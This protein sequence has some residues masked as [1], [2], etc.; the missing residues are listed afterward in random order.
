MS[1]WSRGAKAKLRGL[2]Q[3]RTSTFAL[4]SAP[5]GALGCGR[6]GSAISCS[7][8]SS[9]IVASRSAE[10]SSS[11]PTCATSAIARAGVAALRLELA[12]LARQRVASR[13][14][15]LGAGLQRLALALERR[16]ARDVEER[17][18]RLA[19]LQTRDDLRQVLAQERDVEHGLEWA[20]ALEGARNCRSRLATRRRH[21]PGRPGR[22]GSSSAQPRTDNCGR[23]PLSVVTTAVAQRSQMRDNLIRMRV[24]VAPR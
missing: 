1:T 7:F 17:L 15:F 23:V 16:E 20:A 9:W 12:D 21:R 19:R 10:R 13:L 18:W 5:T 22:L 3:R 8:S 14:Q 24:A 2:P 11:V 4:S 6:L